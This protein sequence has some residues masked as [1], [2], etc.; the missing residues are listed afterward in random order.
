MQSN[1][2]INNVKS[3]WLA[4]DKKLPDMKK[5]GKCNLEKHKNSTGD[6]ISRQRC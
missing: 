5:A 3:Q 6:K 1:S 2:T 4:F